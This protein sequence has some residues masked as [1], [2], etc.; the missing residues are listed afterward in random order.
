MEVALASVAE[1]LELDLIDVGGDVLQLVV[2]VDDEAVVGLVAEVGRS[3][4]VVHLHAA[5]LAVEVGAV[6]LARV[7]HED[8]EALVA[9]GK[10]REGVVD[11]GVPGEF[12]LGIS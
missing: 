8:D 10:A 3:V 6:H 12:V 2:A 5:L 4:D 11:V 1:V 7:G 9:T